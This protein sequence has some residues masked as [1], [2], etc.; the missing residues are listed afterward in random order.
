MRFLVLGP[1]EV[2]LDGREVEVGGGKQRS[3]LALL[4][5]HAGEV[6]SSDRLIE[7][8]WEGQ[9]PATAAKVVQ[10]YVSQLRRR[11]GAETIL[12]RGSGYVLHEVETDAGEFERLVENARGR[13]PREAA[14]D[15]RRALALW[16]GRPFG[17]FE[18]ESWAQPEIARLDELRLSAVEELLSAELQLGEAAKVV[19]ELESLV[20]AY[21]LRE[22][23]RALLMLALYRSG[24]QADAL[25]AFAVARRRL[26]DDLGVEPGRELRDLQRQILAHDPALDSS[27]RPLPVVL[28][29]TPILLVLIGALLVAGAVAAGVIE[30]TS[31][32]SRQIGTRLAGTL[33]E[34][35]AATYHLVGHVAL[36][37]RPARLAADGQLLWT[38]GDESRT[39]SAIDTRTGN[40]EKR[41]SLH[42]LPSDIAVGLGSVWVLDGRTGMLMKVDPASGTVVERRRVVDPNPAYDESREA[43]DPLS[44]ATGLGSIWLTNGSGALLRLDPRT[45]EAA[46]IKL[47]QFVNGIAV[48]PA[49]VWAVSG[50]SAVAIELDS[51]GGL[52]TRVPIA[53]RP[54][55]ESPFPLAV[56]EGAGSVWVLNANTG[57]V[58]RIDP[59]RRAVSAT[60]L[61]GIEH[62]PLRLTVGSGAVWIASGDGT[63][64]RID[65]TSNAVRY[66]S[67]GDRLK[68]VAVTPGRIWI[69]A[70]GGLNSSVNAAA[71]QT[72]TGVHP[73]SALCAPVYYEGRAAPQF[74]IAS[75]F[76]LQA[77]G[78]TTLQMA[79]AIEFVLRRHHFRAGRY[80]IAYQYCDDSSTVPGG[81]SS[82]GCAANARAFSSDTSVIGVIGGFTSSCTAAEI[83]VLNRAPG[84]PLAIISPSASYVG[85]THSGPGTAFGEPGRYYPTGIQNFVRLIATD[86]VQG[87]ADALLAQQ[88]HVRAVYTLD[89][90]ETYGQGL[91]SDFE[92]A[93]R[94][95]GLRL[96]GSAAWNPAAHDYRAIGSRI[97]ES[98]ATAV[99]IAGLITNN[100]V[101]LI[102]AL[103]G[104]L[105]PNVTLIASDGFADRRLVTGV[106]TEAEG[107]IVSVSLLTSPQLPPAG[108]R[109]LN[110]F[111][112][113]VGEKPFADYSV[114]AAEA[115]RVILDAI[116]RSTGT[117]AS[118]T[119]SLLRTKLTNDL[120]GNIAFNRYGD[121]AHGAVTI[122]RVHRGKSTVMTVIRPQPAL[123]ANVGNP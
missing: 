94:K 19:P 30:L 11:L 45:L 39:I 42:A 114:Y 78:P 111:T 82:A 104:T 38:G 84:G 24:R 15:L 33:G 71:G 59:V 119:N 54:G 62:N 95:L 25:E 28:R 99:F 48:G 106:G 81:S 35:D 102:R 118:V 6:I 17:D 89:D 50:P 23:L 3:L 74:L 121:V 60:I 7:A 44:L 80:R 68:D 73:V 53:S 75:D 46:T 55:Y 97:R 41:V 67:V 49:G 103:R 88:L 29:R 10:G 16:R 61:I 34:L 2:R 110:A 14:K 79:Q 96:V 77:M 116:A 100:G 108:R 27:P 20:A 86:D 113:S 47:R 64:A 123:T 109:F 21:P 92:D 83:P 4:L 66:I 31:G 58:T 98:G 120:I 87:A 18:Y 90:G 5:L 1:L 37:G 9:P 72:A 107:V 112:K 115:A 8:L 51:L 36:A 40:M 122:Y 117:R 12:T 105:G 63:L 22:R 57:T 32:S 26:V 70:G 76:P 56:A 91:A 52:L 85:L 93:A 101:K 65:P 43:F 69:T 13:E